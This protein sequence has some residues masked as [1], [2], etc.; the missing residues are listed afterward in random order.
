MVEREFDL[1]VLGCTGFTGTEACKYIAATYGLPNEKFRYGILG[2]SA[3]KLDEV[4]D[5]MIRASSSVRAGKVVVRDGIQKLVSHVEDKEAMEYICKRTKCVLSYLSPPSLVSESVLAACAKTGTHYVDISGELD[6]VTNMRELYSSTAKQNKGK[7]LPCSGMGHAA[8][9]I[10]MMCLAT[11]CT[12][13]G[14]RLAEANKIAQY[15]DVRTPGVSG[16]SL[17]TFMTMF[18]RQP[19]MGLFRNLRDSYRMCIVRP[20][21]N[22]K[23]KTTFRQI[24]YNEDIRRWTSPSFITVNPEAYLRFLRC[25]G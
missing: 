12:T 18:R 23:S 25:F 1:I 17:R 20:A 2:R 19:F 7:I 15:L 5:K 22:A 11:A 3:K 6:W 4:A 16:G 8:N 13:K 21:T 9:D 10:P 14:Y 24:E